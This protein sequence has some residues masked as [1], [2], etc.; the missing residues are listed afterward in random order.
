M[1]RD[2]A[3]L[4]VPEG[5]MVERIA[6]RVLEA[7]GSV[8][9]VGDPAQYAHLGLPVIPDVIPGLGPLSGIHAALSHTGAEW[10]LVVACDM[11]E[12]S[13]E[14]LTEL[15]EAASASSADAVVPRG[16]AGPEPVCAVYRRRLLPALA[17][18][19]GGGLR[20]A[21]D[22]LEIVPVMWLPVAQMSHLRNVNTPEEWA[23]YGIG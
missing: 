4:P 7:S 3:L 17:A 6:R 2:K 19:L 9:L 14:F 23:G 8:T 13:V 22:L 12:V 18:A 10:N 20:K 16:P 21:A 5:V 11:P 15:L 1:G